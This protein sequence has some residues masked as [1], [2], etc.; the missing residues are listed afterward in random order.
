M[1]GGPAFILGIVYPSI[2]GKHPR[3]SCYRGEGP[4]YETA[5][6]IQ[7]GGSTTGRSREAVGGS[8]RQWQ[9]RGVGG[10]E[11]RYETPELLFKSFDSCD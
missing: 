7:Y 5:V 3:D 11:R 6:D 8:G 4:Q 10:R 2:S 9:C 1:G